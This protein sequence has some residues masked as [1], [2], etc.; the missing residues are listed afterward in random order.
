MELHRQCRSQTKN[1][2][3]AEMLDFRRIKLFCFEKRHSKHKMTIFSKNLGGRGPFGPPLATLMSLVH[4]NCA[5]LHHHV[6]L[7][8]LVK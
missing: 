8:F 7:V 6:V 5:V 4:N 1:L 3:G 2:V